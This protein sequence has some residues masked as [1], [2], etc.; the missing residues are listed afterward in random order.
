M[1][2]RRPARTDPLIAIE[3]HQPVRF[4]RLADQRRGLGPGAQRFHDDEQPRIGEKFENL[5]HT[6]YFIVFVNDGES[7]RDQA[8]R[9][10]MDRCRADAA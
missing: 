2:S 6:R 4:Q 9:H 1:V 5:L 8:N 10:R 3:D 7:A